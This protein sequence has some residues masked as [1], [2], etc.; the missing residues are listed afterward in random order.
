MIFLFAYGA[1]HVDENKSNR[2][3]WNIHS[4]VE[5]WDF[6]ITQESKPPLPFTIQGGGNPNH[7]PPRGH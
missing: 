2:K 4:L 1:V 3:T 5:L 6:F 7:P